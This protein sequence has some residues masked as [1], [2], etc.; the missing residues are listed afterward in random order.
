MNTCKIYLTHQH[1]PPVI[2]KKLM[3]ER[4]KKKKK[5]LSFPVRVLPI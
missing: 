4:K 2:V 3:E 1:R 5:E